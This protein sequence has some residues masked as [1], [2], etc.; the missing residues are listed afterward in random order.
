MSVEEWVVSNDEERWSDGDVFA[1]R[2]EAVAFALDEGCRFVALKVAY[3][4]KVDGMHLAEHVIEDLGMAAYED[5]GEVAEEWPSPSR[6]QEKAL[7]T[8]IE[9]AVREWLKDN[10]PCFWVVDKVERVAALQIDE[11]R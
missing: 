2:D 9:R 8:A 3:T 7:A 4:P 1:T 10:P 6:E 5:A 11:R